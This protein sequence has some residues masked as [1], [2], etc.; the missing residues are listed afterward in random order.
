VPPGAIETVYTWVDGAWPGYADL[1]RG[2]ARD[3]H[4]LNPNR[5][6]DN[7]SLL[8]YSLRSL[9]AFAPWIERVT[10]VT[11]RPQV[12]EWLDTRAVRVVHHDEFMPAGILPTFNSF[13]IVRHLDRVPDLPPRFVYIEDDWLLRAPIRPG[14]L[15]DAAGRP[16][17]ALERRRA[18]APERADDTATSPWNRALARSNQLLNARY[19]VRRRTTVG[20]VPLPIDVGG[21]RAM[22][23]T[24]PEAFAQTAASRFRETGNVVPEH[25]YAHF[26]LE[27][28]RALRAGGDARRRGAYHPVNNL[29][30][31]QRLNLA[32]IAW[33]RPAFLCL[34]DDFGGSP[35]PRV[36]AYIRR[37]VEA[38][39]PDRSRFER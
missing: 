2:H 21:W 1:L 11:C 14:D 3:R 6:R 30:L 38:W 16:R 15:F 10:L 27:E 32:R 8:K 35:N 36:V 5:Y 22:I 28:G 29:L 31:F 37:T 34:N 23:D 12:P 7:L 4:D 33:L 9:A 17:V 20:H 25:L 39:F 26:M 18:I 13:A 24:W 19:G